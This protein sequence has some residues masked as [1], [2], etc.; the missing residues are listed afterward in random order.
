M[1]RTEMPK[2]E[3]QMP[4]S[5]DECARLRKV[6]CRLA[7]SALRDRRAAA[8]LELAVG[9]AFS[10]AVKYGAQNSKVSICVEAP[11]NRELAV[12][13]A[14]PGSRFDTAI[15]LPDDPKN[16]SGGFGRYIM[17]T[18]TDSMEYSFENGLTTLRMTKRR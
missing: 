16:V 3:I 11:S 13:M 6:I 9:E 7:S 10:N 18:V 8:D 17:D 12:E 4:S 14:Y 15:K 1:R 2:T 5:A